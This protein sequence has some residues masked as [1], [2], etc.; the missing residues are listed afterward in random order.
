MS[1]RRALGLLV[2]I[3]TVVAVA[4][5]GVAVGTLSQIEINTRKTKLGEAAALQATLLQRDG[6]ALLSG[7]RTEPGTVHRIDRLLGASGH[8]RVGRAS[9]ETLIFLDT[10]WLSSEPPPLPISRDSP[11]AEPM[12][13]ALSGEVGALRT[14]TLAGAPVLVAFHPVAHKGLGVVAELRLDELQQPFIDAA[15]RAA[16]V[17]IPLIL[18]GNVLFFFIARPILRRS[19]ERQARFRELVENMRSGVAILKA[20]EN[21]SNFIVTDFN[22]AAEHIQGDRKSV[23]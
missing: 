9:G 21:G 11:Q 17:G 12:R 22:R 13:R 23:V 8:I 4:V 7:E 20:T 1:D 3:M 2:L 15:K 16:L 19:R 6:D 5:G 10:P 18:V 14:E